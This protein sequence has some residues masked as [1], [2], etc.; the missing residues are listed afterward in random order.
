VGKPEGKNHLE[1]LSVNESTICL[2]GVGWGTDW[3]DLAR[4]RDGLS[5]LVI[6]IIN[7]TSKC[8]EVR[9]C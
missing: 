8:G 3:N 5:D 9:T 1:D 2:Q 4:E 6:V 7:N